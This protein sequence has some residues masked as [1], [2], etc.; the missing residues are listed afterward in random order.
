MQ[1][2]ILFCLS[3][4]GYILLNLCLTTMLSYC[5]HIVPIGPKLTTPQLLL[6]RWYPLKYL[7][8]RDTFDHPYYFRRTIGR[9]ALHQKM[10]M[11]SIRSYFYKI[12]FIPLPYFH[13]HFS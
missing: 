11:V 2:N 3:L 4:V 8:R 12:N 7:A 13:A 5:T 6:Y 1:S 10:H 9:H